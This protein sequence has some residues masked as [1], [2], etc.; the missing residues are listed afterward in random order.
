M[1]VVLEV[2]SSVPIHSSG[3]QLLV[4]VYTKSSHQFDCY[5]ISS[6]HG[7][8]DIDRVGKLANFAVELRSCGC[9]SIG[10]CWCCIDD[11][12]VFVMATLVLLLVC[13]WMVLDASAVALNDVTFEMAS[14]CDRSPSWHSTS[15]S[16]V[17]GRHLSSL[18]QSRFSEN[19]RCEQEYMKL[20][21]DRNN[22]A[23]MEC[24]IR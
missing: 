21:Y 10:C 23:T 18:S 4:L 15:N 14:I 1:W 9:C 12:F 8:S 22:Q 6:S 2:S 5:K 3:T 16:M 19:R 24:T 7:G 17:S 20:I 13:V 11:G